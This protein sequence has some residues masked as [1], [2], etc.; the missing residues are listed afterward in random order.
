MWAENLVI[1]NKSRTKYQFILI[2]VG[3]S[4]L[5]DQVHRLTFSLLRANRKIFLNYNTLI[6][7][8]PIHACLHVTANPFK[9]M[10]IDVDNLN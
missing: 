10:K 9:V 6:V 1:P 8:S 4:C 5:L 2:V 3:K 7:Y